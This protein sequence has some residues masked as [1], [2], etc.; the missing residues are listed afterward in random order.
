MTYNI[1]FCHECTYPH[2]KVTFGNIFWFPGTRTISVIPL[3][4]AIATTTSTAT[5][6]MFPKLDVCKVYKIYH[7]Y[8]TCSIVRCDKCRSYTSF[9]KQCTMRDKVFINS[10]IKV[11]GE[12]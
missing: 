10:V 7:F 3:T 12:Q 11:K 2:F 4:T 6:A 1:E 9:S 8:L 5:A